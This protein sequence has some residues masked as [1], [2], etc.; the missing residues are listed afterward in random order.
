MDY[1]QILGVERGAS[2]EELKR[3][4]RDKV[5]QYHP[6][7]NPEPEAVEHFHRV[8]EAYRVLSNDRLRDEYIL[9]RLRK[10]RTENTAWSRKNR[11]H[12]PGVD[13]LHIGFLISA[14]FLFMWVADTLWNDI[15]QIAMA[16]EPTLCS[17]EGWEQLNSD[18]FV[19]HYAAQVPW[20]IEPFYN[21]RTFGETSNKFVTGTTFE[22]Y[23]NQEWQATQLW[24]YDSGIIWSILPWGIFA[25]LLAGKAL[26]HFFR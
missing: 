3:A 6:D 10:P 11:K 26:R 19:L 23:Y 20:Q 4:Y 17:V 7:M 18:S 21:K 16:A 2:A 25:I 24:R 8:V 12:H 1:Y 15:I 13:T 5:R 9:S 22:C 14:F